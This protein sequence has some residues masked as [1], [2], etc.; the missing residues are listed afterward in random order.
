MK[1]SIVHKINKI[2][3]RGARV[4]ASRAWVR[5]ARKFGRD[6]S[7]PYLDWIEDHTPAARSW[8]PS[9]RWCRERANACPGSAC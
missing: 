4:V 7:D 8:S 9:G 1:Y 5:L 6:L 3:E 2:K